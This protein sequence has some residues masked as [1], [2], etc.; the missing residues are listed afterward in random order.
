MFIYLRT[1][2]EYRFSQ[3]VILLVYDIEENR[4]FAKTFEEDPK[5]FQSYI[6]KFKYNVRQGINIFPIY[7]TLHMPGAPEILMTNQE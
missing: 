6:N 3:K 4:R 1:L 7:H 2:S 5:L